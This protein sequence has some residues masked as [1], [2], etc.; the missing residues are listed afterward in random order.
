MVSLWEE[1]RSRSSWETTWDC[2]PLLSVVCGRSSTDKEARQVYD[3]IY[4]NKPASYYNPNEFPFLGNTARTPTT[5]KATSAAG[6][7]VTFE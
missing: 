5:H 6:C 7:Q 3:D 1:Q 4:A 2:D